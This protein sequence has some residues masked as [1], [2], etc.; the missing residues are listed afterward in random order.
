MLSSCLNFEQSS[1]KL[2]VQ[3]VCAAM[4]PNGNQT[5]CLSVHSYVDVPLS[6]SN[7]ALAVSDPGEKMFSGF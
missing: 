3:K 7:N 6:N 1:P 2:N 4:L 5:N